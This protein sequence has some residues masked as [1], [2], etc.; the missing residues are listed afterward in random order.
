MKRILTLIIFYSITLNIFLL[1]AQTDTHSPYKDRP[2]DINGYPIPN[3]KGG[4]DGAYKSYYKNGQLETSMTYKKGRII[5]IYQEFYENGKLRFE[6]TYNE[7][8]EIDGVVKSF[9]ESGKL[10]SSYTDRNGQHHGA[11]KEYY[12]NGQL[13]EEGRYEYGQRIYYPSQNAES[14]ELRSSNSPNISQGNTEGNKVQN[15]T[16]KEPINKINILDTNIAY[17]IFGT[18]KELTN[19]KIISG[20]TVASNNTLKQYLDKNKNLFIK[21]DIRNIKVIPV[22][23][24]KAKVLSS[25]PINSFAL[26][27][28]TFGQMAIHILDPI[29]FWS[30][31]RFLII[32][33][34]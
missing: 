14:N 5:G 11:Y 28:D 2:K 12:E 21:S 25:H 34:G 6:A 1:N 13:K 23:A 22:Y 8:G 29:A 17:Y 20:E 3:D 16:E 18:S 4:K 15:N 7:D 31:S 33:V 32:Q 30:I 10:S 26:K 19:A 9:Y 24:K 27:G